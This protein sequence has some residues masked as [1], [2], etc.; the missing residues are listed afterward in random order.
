MKKKL[1]VI[2]LIIMAFMI[3]FSFWWWKNK[4]DQNKLEQDK[5]NYNYN[6]FIE[7]LTNKAYEISEIKSNEE[8]NPLKIFS[9][10]AKRIKVNGGIIGVYE[11][12]NSD[13]AKKDAA[14]ISNN[15]FTIGHSM[16]SWVSDPHF[17]RKGK[18]IIEY[19][20]TNIKLLK[21]LESIVGSQIAG[22][23]YEGMKPPDFLQ[24]LN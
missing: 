13:M 11:F 10:Y 15:A 4:S 12:E 8:V 20:G 1:R 14:T 5:I 6:D 2:I 17:F 7:D 22:M 24:T 23:N 16:I 18:V 19:V 3:I 9:V 21:D